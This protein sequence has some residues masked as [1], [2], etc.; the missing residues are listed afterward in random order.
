MCV[1]ICVCVCVCVCVCYSIY[2]ILTAMNN[3]S[4]CI[5]HR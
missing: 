3:R 1:C 5:I 2:L 4:A